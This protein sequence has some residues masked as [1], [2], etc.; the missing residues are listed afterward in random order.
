[1]FL[2]L[3]NRLKPVCKRTLR[4]QVLEYINYRDRKPITQNYSPSAPELE[5]YELMSQSLQ[6]EKLYDLPFSQRHCKKFWRIMV[7]HLGKMKKGQ[8]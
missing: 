5:L 6:T 7:M 4:C 3:R 8:F 2:D 1:M